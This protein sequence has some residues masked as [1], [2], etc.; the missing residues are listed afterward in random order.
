MN[1][2]VWRKLYEV[3]PI[4]TYQAQGC[5][6]PASIGQAW[7]AMRDD[8][9]AIRNT[10]NQSRY[11]VACIGI[12]ALVPSSQG[13]E[14]CR[15]STRK[16]WS[17]MVTLLDK[18]MKKAGTCRDLDFRRGLSGDGFVTKLVKEYGSTE[19]H[20]LSASATRVLTHTRIMAAITARIRRAVEACGIDWE[21]RP[22]GAVTEAACLAWALASPGGDG[23]PA[24][25]SASEDATQMRLGFAQVRASGYWRQLRALYGAL[26]AAAGNVMLHLAFDRE[27]RLAAALAAPGGFGTSYLQAGSGTRDAPRKATVT[28]APSASADDRQRAD[29]DAEAHETPA[30]AG[31]TPSDY[32]DMIHRVAENMEAYLLS[33]DAV[34]VMQ[35]AG[36]AGQFGEFAEF[37]EAGFPGCVPARESSVVITEIEDDDDAS[38]SSPAVGAQR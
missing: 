18:A 38:A 20:G 9:H 21:A 26:D 8:L 25:K 36:T 16:M 31:P 14:Q 28:F 12:Q 27:M 29:S 7:E 6:L 37:A 19:I 24:A 32:A 22:A 10:S 3:T 2:P 5:V 1:D 30:M 11:M 35:L 15:V 34:M 4:A 17:S 23:V 13:A 33:L